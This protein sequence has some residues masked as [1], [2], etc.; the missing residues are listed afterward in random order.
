MN[1]A[2]PA[3]LD[4][5]T[6]A[7]LKGRLE[8]IADEMDATLYRSAF[9]PIIAEARDACHGVYDAIT[10]DTLVQGTKGLPIFVG[11]MSFA[12]RSVIRKVAAEG[13]LQEGDTFLFNDPYDGG[14]HLN[15]FRLVRPVFRA[16]KLLG[17]ECWPLA[18]Y[19]R[20]CA[21]QLQS[22]R[23][24]QPSGRCTFPTSKIDPRRANAAGYSGYLGRQFTR[25]AI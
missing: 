22:A 4:A 10:G 6:L 21:R 5:V 25:A 15:D 24:R 14:T 7:V 16:G 23:D 11:A 8:Q 9:N 20:Q 17:G 13:G 19:R 12:V 18:G 1:E 3:R 2:S